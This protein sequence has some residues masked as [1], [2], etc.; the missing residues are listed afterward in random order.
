MPGVTDRRRRTTAEEGAIDEVGRHREITCP[1]G[2]EMAAVC[3]VAADGV[4][5]VR[6]TAH[7]VNHTAAATTPRIVTDHGGSRGPA[8]TGP[9]PPRRPGCVAGPGAGVGCSVSAGT[10]GPST[11]TAGKVAKI[12]MSSQPRL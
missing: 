12:S 7:T 5:R 11:R 9:G 6:S 4:Q 1:A 3:A 10:G 8:R 2:S